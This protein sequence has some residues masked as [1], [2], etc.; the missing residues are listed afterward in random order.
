MF[1]QMQ[2]PPCFAILRCHESDTSD[3]QIAEFLEKPTRWRDPSHHV[4]R[5]QS[6]AAAG[7]MSLSI[8][9]FAVVDLTGA[10]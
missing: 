10:R 9:A 8:S 2:T 6:D 4:R 5:Q 3:V 7:T 1:A